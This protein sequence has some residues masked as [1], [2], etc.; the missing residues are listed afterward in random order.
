LAE[1]RKK[2]GKK[3]IFLE[4]TASVLVEDSEFIQLKEVYEA[5]KLRIPAIS[6]FESSEKQEFFIPVSI[7][8]KQL[9]SLEAI[10][11]YLIENKGLSL[12]QISSLLNRSNRNIWNSYNSSKKKFPHKLV[13]KESQLIPC[14]VLRDLRHTLLENIVSY[15]KGSFNLSYHQIAV[16]LYRDDRTIWTVYKRAQKK[17][18]N[19]K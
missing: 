6:I 1:I 12:K 19:A 3:D 11:K 13:V 8:N 4:N 7:F 5:L 18:P 15:L 17:K 2:S 9:S 10:S 14:S 16:M